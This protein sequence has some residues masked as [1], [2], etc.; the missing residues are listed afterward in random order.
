[1][2]KKS[3][4]IA[5]WIAQVI[6]ALILFQTLFFKFTGAE[7]SVYIFTKLGMEPLGRIGS[8]VAELIAVVLLLVP[9]TVV[10]GAILA[11]GV[12][13]GAIGSHLTVLGI[14]VKGDGGLLF[15]LACVVFA[16][17]VAILAIRRMSI[18]VIGPRLF[19]ADAAASS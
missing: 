13:V 6:V 3:H 7:E 12:I 15:A 10:F 11:L 2:L 4:N 9:R 1:M 5:S 16:G 8:G 19:G 17:S 18:P 14:D